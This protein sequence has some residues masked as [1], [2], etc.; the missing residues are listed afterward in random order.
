M[1]MRFSASVII[2]VSVISMRRREGSILNSSIKELISAK[3][4]MNKKSFGEMLIEMNRCDFSPVQV[5]RISQA[6]RQI[7]LSR[8][9]IMP[10]FSNVGIK[11]S[12]CKKPS[13]GWSQR[14]SASA[15]IICPLLSTM[16]CK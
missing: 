10:F 9:A 7:Y 14:I 4:S 8:S 6:L 16:G 15:P 5:E 12:G 3:T 1:A 2:T 11:V 13:L